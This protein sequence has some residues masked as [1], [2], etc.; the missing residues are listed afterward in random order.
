[1]GPAHLRLKRAGRGEVGTVAGLA[2]QQSLDRLLR[3]GRP[4]FRDGDSDKIWVPHGPSGR[5]RAK[6]AGP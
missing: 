5:K 3:E 6:A 2:S 1:M 4:E